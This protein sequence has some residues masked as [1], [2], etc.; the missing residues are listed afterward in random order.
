MF[1]NDIYI[2]E[3]KNIRKK[4]LW[5]QLLAATLVATMLLGVPS[6]GIFATETNEIVS[7]ETIRLNEIIEDTEADTGVSDEE[8]FEAEKTAEIEVTSATETD[9]FNY[10]INEDGTVTITEYTGNDTQVEIPE[11]IAGKS[12][13]SIGDSAFYDCET[14]TSI[15]IPDSVTSIGEW[16]FRACKSLTS[17]NIPSSVTCIGSQAFQECRELTNISIPE[18]VTSIEYATFASCENLM[19]I[20][21]PEGTTSIGQSAFFNCKKLTNITLPE[22]ITSIG[23]QAFGGCERLVNIV[24]PEGV[25]SIGQSAFED[26]KSLINITISEGLLSIERDTFT[27]CTHLTSVALPSSLLSIGDYAFQEC[28]SLTGITISEGL[29]SIGDSAFAG[30]KSLTSINIPS[31]VTNIGDSAFADCEGLT[32]ITISESLTGI[33][34]SVFA[35]CKSLAVVKIPDSVTSIGNSA[36]DG[37]E[38]LTSITM[39]EGLTNIGDSAFADCKSLTSIN[40]PS[41]VTSIGEQTFESCTGLTN[42]SIPEGVTSIGQAAF[43]DCESLMNITISEAEGLLYIER[44]TFTYCTQLTSVALPSSLLSIDDSAFEGCESLTSITMSEGLTSIGDST[45]AGCKSLPAINIP[46][47]VTSI[48]DSA[49]EG[50]EDLTSITMSEC[51]TSI[52]DS[53]FAGCKSLLAINIPG[54]VTSIGD[55]AFEEC[56]D[57]KNVEILDNVTSIGESAFLLSGLTSIK[58]PESVMYIADDAFDG[59]DALV[60]YCSDT[61]YA[62]QY[63]IDNNI[64][65][66]SL[67]EWG[68]TTCT[69]AN[70]EIRN[71]TS[72]TCTE[73][74][75]TGDIYCIDCGELIANGTAIAALGHT[76]TGTITTQPT[77]TSEGVKTYTCSRCGDIYT[78]T[79]AKLT[80]THT[81]TEVRNAKSAT[82]TETGY[83]GDTYCIDCGELISGGTAIAA[84]GHAYTGTI[85]TQP[86]VTSEGVKTYTCSRCGDTYTEAIAKLTVSYTVKFNGNGAT[87]GSMTNQSITYGVATALTANGFQKKGYTFKNWNTSKDGSGTAYANKADVSKLTETNGAEITL[88][89]QWT[90]NKYT[91]TFNGNGSN[92]GST[93]KLSGCKYGKK[94]TLTKNGFK[95]KG[96]TF[97]GWNTKKDGS[98]KSYKN[99]AEVKNLTSKSGGKVTLYAQWKKTKYTITY[100]LNKGK[101]NKNN[102]ASYNVTTK[103]VKL[104]NPTRKGYT[105]KGW[106]SDKKCTKKVTQIKKGSTGNITLYAKWKKK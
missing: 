15:E 29:T 46:S 35:D 97:K 39:G 63:A 37:C 18:G 11:E 41:S 24:L 47:S 71:V 55:S 87:G 72:A 51:L 3:K 98:G 56:E 26:C 12:V 40:I 25:T 68:K 83:T 69:H 60:I 48:G 43:K 62:R 32:S 70:T 77:V 86:T 74:G 50:C 99:K 89:A 17:I 58:I 76:Y 82:C 103:T 90:A 81:N 52:R 10:E 93:K 5:K 28:E 101:N 100:N 102:P 16:A 33:G 9:N 84:L 27:R 75:Y 6:N 19:S 57:L 85:T 66:K 45:F 92:S 42:I 49:F 2:G 94:Y 95:K 21:L 105:F 8:V 54:S 79:I 59:C 65:Y 4:R 78:E 34:D 91:I 53:A 22:G 20:T 13:T 64:R 80:C 104:K 7:N 44:D 23:E 67:D 31:S 106:Y 36:F 30:C 61:S 38:N 88:Y 14:L 96:Y 1:K 73:T